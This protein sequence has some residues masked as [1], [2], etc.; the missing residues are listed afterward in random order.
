MDISLWVENKIIVNSYIT[1]IVSM[2][3]N[4][5]NRNMYNNIIHNDKI[6]PGYISDDTFSH[7]IQNYIGSKYTVKNSRLSCHKIFQ[8]EEQ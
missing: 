8:R 4:I 7:N 5:N 6:I 3:C 1:R 2:E